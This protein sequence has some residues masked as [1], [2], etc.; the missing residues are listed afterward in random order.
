MATH[1]AGGLGGSPVVGGHAQGGRDDDGRAV[2]Q[3]TVRVVNDLEAHVAQNVR[4]G[5]GCNSQSDVSNGGQRH[6]PLVLTV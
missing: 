2:H 4:R 5:A 1:L 6:L 3:R